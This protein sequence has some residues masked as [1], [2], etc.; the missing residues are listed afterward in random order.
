[1]EKRLKFMPKIFKLTE[2][3]SPA[4]VFKHQENL[5]ADREWAKKKEK[6]I[7]PHYIAPREVELSVGVVNFIKNIFNELRV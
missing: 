1:M 5:R 2:F 7:I 4:D 6:T 3:T